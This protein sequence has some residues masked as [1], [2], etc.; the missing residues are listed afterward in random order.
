MNNPFKN[1]KLH[2]YELVYEELIKQKPRRLL[3]Y[4][5]G[6]SEFVSQL[7]KVV[8]Q[9]Y[10]FDVDRNNVQTT[11]KNYPEIKTK[12]VPVGKKLPYKANFFDAV[13]MFHVLEHVDDELSA[14]RE[15]TRIL[16]KDGILYLASPY[17]GLFT[18]ADTANLRYRFPKFHKL[19]IHLILG[20]KEYDKRF[21]E[22][23]DQ[24]LFG[25]CSANRKWHKHYVK[26]E[27]DELTKRDLVEMHFYRFSM[28]H[29]FLL[30]IDNVWNYFSSKNNKFTK[31][32]LAKDNHIKAGEWSYNFLG[33]YK[34]K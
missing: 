15:A 12:Y 2:H 18:W 11:Q 14:L 3:D 31:M 10:A 1:H 24:N 21:K 33:I 13:I 9:R 27:I 7:D 16:K 6:T 29:P 17:K 20:Q 32:L 23:A 22:K 34:K 26:P 5:T 4:G 25:D 8:T 28:F 30:V 19:F